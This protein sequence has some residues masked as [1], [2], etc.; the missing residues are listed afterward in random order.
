MNS[1]PMQYTRMIFDDNALASWND[2]A[3]TSYTA[4]SFGEKLAWR[5]FEKYTKDSTYFVSRQCT[6]GIAYHLISRSLN[7]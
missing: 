5:V 4:T 2:F 6:A 1:D 3:D 7:K